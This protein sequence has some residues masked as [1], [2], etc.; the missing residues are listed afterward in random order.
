MQLSLSKS[1]FFLFFR[2]DLFIFATAYHKL[3]LSFRITILCSYIIRTR[4]RVKNF[5]NYN[6]KIYNI[7]PKMLFCNDLKLCK[8]LDI[9]KNV[10]AL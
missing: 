3:I 2:Y 6:D 8:I 9:F 7:F 4:S 10:T 1:L 5:I